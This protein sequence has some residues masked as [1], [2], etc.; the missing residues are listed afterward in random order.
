MKFSLESQSNNEV[1]KWWAQ[2]TRFM[3]LLFATERNFRTDQ[4]EFNAYSTCSYIYSAWSHPSY[5][6][7]YIY[8]IRIYILVSD[9][10]STVPALRDVPV[11]KFSYAVWEHSPLR[12]SMSAV[13]HDE[14]IW[15]KQIK[16]RRP[17]YQLVL[18]ARSRALSS[19]PIQK[20]NTASVHASKGLAN[21][22]KLSRPLRV[23]KMKG[24]PSSRSGNSDRRAETP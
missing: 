9:N 4:L 24:S 1:R 22:T 11:S 21:K 15:S 17:C 5:I 13:S 16:A 3:K 8:D 12:S 10:E 23:E 20:D 2:C 19:S 14:R 18:L 7:G 6:C